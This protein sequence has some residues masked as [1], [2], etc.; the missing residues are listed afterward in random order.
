MTLCHFIHSG[1]SVLTV[2]IIVLAL[3]AGKFVITFIAYALSGVICLS[4]FIINAIIF[5]LRGKWSDFEWH[6]K[7]PDGELFKRILL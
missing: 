5:A 2:I 3:L 7:S 6:M 1:D 4:I